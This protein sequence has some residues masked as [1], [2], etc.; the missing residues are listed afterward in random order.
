MKNQEFDL[1]SILGAASKNKKNSNENNLLEE[2]QKEIIVEKPIINKTSS[3]LE[4]NKLDLEELSFQKIQKQLNKKKTQNFY[5]PI[6]LLEKLENLSKEYKITRSEI[7]E[8]I[9]KNILK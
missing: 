2:T 6:Y 8:S 9:L 4:T 1:N 3:Q 7:L 5:L